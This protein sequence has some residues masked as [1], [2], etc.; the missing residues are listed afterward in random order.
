MDINGNEFR[1]MVLRAVLK[2]LEEEKQQQQCER[3]VYVVFSRSFDGPWHI[4]QQELAKGDAFTAIVPDE[5]PQ[6]KL[7][8]L[9]AEFPFRRIV[10]RT[11]SANL[12]LVGSLT[13]YPTISHTFAAKTALCIQDTFAT[14]WLARCLAAG[15]QIHFMIDGLQKF[16][17]HEPDAYVQQI[18]SYY[19]TILT[20]GITIGS[21][22]STQHE[23]A[24]A[25]SIEPNAAAPQITLHSHVVTTADI[26]RYPEG[27]TIHLES[28]AVV[29]SLAQE[30]ADRRQ[31]A[32]IRESY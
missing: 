17:G 4:S 20:Y 32:L 9:M 16:T 2:V 28:G 15:S 1:N 29:T 8:Q 26:H 3:T 21:F 30:E 7:C 6:D 31:I 19:K 12:P 24:V 25:T 27:T 5:W 23:P 22:Q 11:E 14:Q 10:S 18:L 13:V